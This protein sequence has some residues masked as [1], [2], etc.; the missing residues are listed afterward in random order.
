MRYLRQYLA[1][2]LR[3]RLTGLSPERFFNLC[4]MSGIELW[5]VSESNGEYAFSMAAGDFSSCRPLVKKAKVRLAI[6]K[7]LGLPFFLHKN[8][9][10]KLWAAG[11]FS[12][13]LFLYLLSLFIWD[14]EYQGNFT[15]TDDQLSHYLETLNV[16]CGMRK[17]KVSCEELESAVRNEFNGVTWVSARLSGTRL[18]I[19]VKENDVPLTVPKRDESPCD[20]TA[21]YDGVITSMIVRNGKALVK[22]GDAVKKGQ[23]LVSGRIP[24]T[25]DGGTEVAA[26]YVHADAD[27]AARVSR[28][29]EKRISMWH[30]RKEKTGRRRCGLYLSVSGHSFVW[31]FPNLW[32]T[33]WE[34]VMEEHKLCI[35]KDFYLPVNYGLVRS[36]EISPYEEKYKENELSDMALAYKNELT[37][38]LM[39]KGVHIIENNVKILVSGS[40]CLFR[41]ELITEEPITEYAEPEMPEQP[42][43]ESLQPPDHPGA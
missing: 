10:R 4:R 25:D 9:A 19:H 43:Q 32:K 20:L 22:P 15:Y 1:G 12:F 6:N 16:H 2:F 7:K 31:L 17:S 33:P 40:E 13:F 27:V 8:R 37:E 35:A 5:N 38:N 29:E 41:A 34:T 39:Q 28:T 18:Y 3:V 23:L 36:E 30:V 24:I 11:F 26:H 42:E 21:A 14:I